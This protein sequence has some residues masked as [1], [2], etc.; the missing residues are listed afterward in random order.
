[1]LFNYHI[2]VFSAMTQIMRAI[3]K[4]EGTLFYFAIFIS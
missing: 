3:K 2:I 1:M 4:N